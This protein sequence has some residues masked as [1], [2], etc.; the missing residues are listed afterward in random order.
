[1]LIPSDW[2]FLLFTSIDQ[3]LWSGSW[4]GS[5]TKNGKLVTCLEGSH[6]LLSEALA[7]AV[8]CSRLL[9]GL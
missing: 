2:E 4:V 9:L 5:W 3:P 7:K 8:W 1:M 6:G